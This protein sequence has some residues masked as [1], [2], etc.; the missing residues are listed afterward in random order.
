MEQDIIPLQNENI[1][2]N[3]EFT[4]QPFCEKQQICRHRR[5]TEGKSEM[6]LIKMKSSGCSIPVAH[7]LSIV[8]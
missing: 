2:L 3:T 6:R 8:S 5:E 1:S 4:T 7:Q